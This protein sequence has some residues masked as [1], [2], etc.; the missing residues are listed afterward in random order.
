M[1]NSEGIPVAAYFICHVWD[2]EGDTFMTRGDLDPATWTGTWTYIAGT[3]KFEGVTGGGTW[4]SGPQFQG[5]DDMLYFNS[6]V[7]LPN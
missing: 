4:N 3:G 1:F 5:E 6:S 2:T 7:E